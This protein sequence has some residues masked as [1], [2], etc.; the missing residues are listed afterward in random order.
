MY[1]YYALLLSLEYS[2]GKFVLNRWLNECAHVWSH[3]L[4]VLSIVVKTHT[5][6]VFPMVNMLY[7]FA[8]LFYADDH[9]RVMLSPIDGDPDSDYIN[10]NTIDVR[11]QI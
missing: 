6:Y 2:Q 1:D 8:I 10:A 3:H 7:H 11:C 4:G 9:S 5:H